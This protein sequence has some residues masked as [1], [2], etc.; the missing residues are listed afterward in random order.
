MTTDVGSTVP[1]GAA[2][3]HLGQRVVIAGASGFMGR[4][5]AH[6]FRQDGATVTSVGRDD[7]D[8]RWG[9]SAALI[10]AV[11]GADLLLNLAGRSVNCRYTERNRAVIFRSRIDTTAELGWAV[12]AAEVPPELWIN[13]STATI[14]RHADDHGQTEGEGDIGAGFSVDVATSWEDAFFAV[15]RE[16]LRQVAIRTAIVLGAGSAL[17][18]LTTL[19]RLGL[20]GPQ[21]GGRSG[22]G[23]QMFSWIHLDDVWRAIEFLQQHPEVVGPVNLS[24]P[25]PVQNR[26]LMRVLRGVLGV[27]VGLP[28][29][30]WMLR[31]GAVALHTEPELLLKSRWVLPS[32]LLSGGFVFEYPDLRGALEQ[33]IGSGRGR[34]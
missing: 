32:R 13:S 26:E 15:R 23:R 9:D 25:N 20:G 6:R 27:H 29:A 3:T 30:A 12:I 31:A 33:I 10:R 11:S 16:G 17:T 1:V 5:L 14:Y 7:A 18:P 34:S 21:L 8:V 28:A 24:S 4:H 22:G 19:T 2:Q